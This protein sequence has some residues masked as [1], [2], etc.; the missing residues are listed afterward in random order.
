MDGWMDGNPA[1]LFG[2][3]V[4]PVRYCNV[5][6]MGYHAYVAISIKAGW[7]LSLS[8]PPSDRSISVVFYIAAVMMG[9]T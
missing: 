2:G 4:F 6:G 7:A 1:L 3:G 9:V 5:T 8:L